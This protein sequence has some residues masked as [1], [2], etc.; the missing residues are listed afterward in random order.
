MIG[1]RVEGVSARPRPPT[2][3]TKCSGPKTSACRARAAAMRSITCRLSVRKGEIVGLYGLMG[4]G[5]TEFLECVMAQHPPSGGRLFVDGRA[6]GRT[7]RGRPDR[8]RYCADPRG[9]QA[10]RPGADHVDPRKPDAVVA[11]ADFTR[12]FHLDLKA[13]AR[14]GDGIRQAADDQGRQPRKSGLQPVGRQPAEGGD[15]QGADDQAEDPADGR[16]QPRASTSAPRPKCS[17][18]CAT[19]PPRGWASCS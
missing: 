18:P 14:Q 5:R 7:R 6:A 1:E 2:S 12:L 16:T 10:R 8:A 19:W 9:S 3:A 4:A 17:A 11:W 13:E 15:R